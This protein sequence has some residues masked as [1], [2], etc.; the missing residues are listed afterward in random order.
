MHAIGRSRLGYFQVPFVKR[1]SAPNFVNIWFLF[2]DKSMKYLTGNMDKIYCR[3]TSDYRKEI[4]LELEMI[5]STIFYNHTVKEVSYNTKR[6]VGIL[7][8]L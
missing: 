8:P 4:A 5:K 2:R 1:K 6:Y 3:D 7:Y